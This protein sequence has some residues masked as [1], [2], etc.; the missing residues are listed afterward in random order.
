MH[1][2]EEERERGVDQF[3]S[4]RRRRQKKEEARGQSLESECG[5][6]RMRAK[7]G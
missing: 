2:R 7:K 5:G 1:V 3:H 4:R 6:G